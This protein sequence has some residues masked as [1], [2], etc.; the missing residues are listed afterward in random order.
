MPLAGGTP[1]PADNTGSLPGQTFS[2]GANPPGSRRRGQPARP[3]DHRHD[4]LLGGGRGGQ[5]WS[6]SR[7]AFMVDGRLFTGWS[8]GTPEVRSFDGTTFGAARRSTC[9][10]SPTSPPS[11]PTSPVCSTTGRRRACTSRCRTV[12]ALLPLLPARERHRRR[13]AL[14]RPGQP[15]DI[16]WSRA[17]GMFLANGGRLTR[18]P[19]RRR[20][21]LRQW[22]GGA[23]STGR[24]DR[25]AGRRTRRTGLAGSF[26]FL[27]PRTT[28]AEWRDAAA[29]LRPTATL[30]ATRRRV[31]ARVGGDTC[32]EVPSDLQSMAGRA[33]SAPHSHSD[34][35]ETR[36]ILLS[37]GLPSGVPT[38][39]SRASSR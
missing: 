6:S 12:P 35:P 37:G 2:L 8:N 26:L 16:D 19:G 24:D 31:V 14:R 21:A 1:I 28:P 17:G 33:D 10:A 30:C 11:C 15:A 13:G 27:Y 18:R 7:G 9:T 36:R 22:S 3:H 39:D 38:N 20:P 23:R 34:P 25:V 5:D 29:E 4:L 32:G